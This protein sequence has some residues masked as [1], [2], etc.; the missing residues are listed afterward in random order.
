MKD[1]TY[2]DAFEQWSFAT[3]HFDESIWLLM[4]HYIQKTQPMVIMNR[5]PS[6]NYGSLMVF[7]IK[8]VERGY[9]D[10]MVLYV[11]I[12]VLNK[13]NADFDGDRLNLQSIKIRSHQKEFVKF[14]DPRKAMQISRLDGKYDKD[15]FLIKDQ[16][17]GLHLFNSI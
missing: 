16:L 5:N 7:K 13:F 10:N 4:N 2:N 3:T 6:I 15:L 12:P 17:V 11:S 9:H 1:V 8:L 14:L